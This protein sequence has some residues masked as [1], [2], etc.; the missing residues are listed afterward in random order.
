MC[1]RLCV[2]VSGV[3]ERSTEIFHRSIR[4]VNNTL[5]KGYQKGR[6]TPERPN[7]A[8]AQGRI[9][10]R[11]SAAE[12]GLRGVIRPKFCRI[13]PMELGGYQ[14]FPPLSSLLILLDSSLSSFFLFLLSHPFSSSSPSPPPG[15]CCLC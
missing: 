14:Y 5:P 11:N 8:C 2:L 1:V 6:I 12:F 9:L 4:C 7:S 3:R 15:C 13:R 10:R